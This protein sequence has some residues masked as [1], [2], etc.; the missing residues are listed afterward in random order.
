MI[1]IIQFAL[2]NRF[3]MVVIGILVLGAGYLSYTKLPIDAFPDVSPTL[4]QVFTVS[5]GYSPE[6]IEKYVTFPIEAAMSG[7]P[8]LQLVRSISNFGLS[9]VNLYFDD[10]TDVYFSRQVVGER[11]K[12]AAEQIPEGFGT[13]QM[14]PITSGMGL[15][16]Y[17]YLEDTTG[18]YSLTEL[19]SIQDWLIR[20]PLQTVPGVTEVLGI[21]GWV[22]QY[23]TVL[24]PEALIRYNL[25]VNEI[26]DRIRANNLN[27]GAQF[28]VKNSE[29]FTVRSVGLTTEI[30]DIKNIVVKSVDGIPIYLKQL[31][32]IKVGGAARYGASTRN[33]LGEVVVGQII[34]LFGANSSQVIKDIEQKLVQINGM[35]PDGVTIKPY[36]EQKTLVEAAV[37]TVT[38]ALEEAIIL[39]ILILIVF[40]GAFRPSL[41]VAIAIPFSSLF[42]IIGMDFLGISAN[43]MSFGGIAIAIG[44]MV[45]GSVVI[46]E[47]VDRMLRS[48][49]PGESRIHIILRASVEVLRPIIFAVLI[50]IVV[51]VPLFT[52]EGV[53][54]KT[55][56]PLAYTIS[57]A[58][59][60]SLIFAVFLAPVLSYYLM[61]RPK[62]SKNQ[63][64]EEHQIWI[65]RMMLKIYHPLVTF[66]VKKRSAAVI[67]ATVILIIG[68]MIYP[69]LGSEFTPR[70]MEET[71]V[72]RLTLA[73]S[74]SLDEG[75]R[76]TD[77]VEKRLMKIPDIKEVVSRIGRGEVGSD[78][79]PINVVES[80][81]Q[82][83]PRE[84]W[85]SAKTQLGLED[86]IREKLSDVPGIA[87]NI[88]QPIQ[89]RVDELLSGVRAQIAIKL[90][91]DDLDVLKEKSD[92][93]LSIIEKIPGA[94]DV[95]VNQIGGAPQLLIK[96]DRHKI[97]RYGINIK[98]VQDVIQT[99]IGGSTAGQFFEGVK[100]FDIFVRFAAEFRSTPEQI[101]N[102]LVEAPNGVL[103]PLSQ[104]ASVE[105]IVG[106]RQI[107]REYSQRFIT[108][109]SNVV[110][111]DVGTFVKKGIEAIKSKVN[112]PPGYYVEWG[113][114]FK[115]Q[116]AANSRLAVVMP[117][118]LFIIFILLFSNFNSFKNALL[119][120]LNIP[121]ALVGGI[122]ALWIAGLNLSV[123]ASVGFIALFGIALLN[124]IVLLT[125]FNQ[126][127]K[128]GY[129]I[130]EASIQGA[131]LRLRPVLMTAFAAALGM[132]PL[133]FSTGIGSEVQRPLATVVVGGLFTSTILT[134]LVLP[135]L[136]KWFAIKIRNEEM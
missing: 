105:E 129:S 67:L 24:N 112:L 49:D 104:L 68:G 27:V 136:Y 103:V 79:E 86:V 85:T 78:A 39:V 14:G 13:P 56:R 119:I 98:D 66:F 25:S 124:G 26:L 42:A 90:F 11:L 126:L 82:L 59:A 110:G 35:L 9:I 131:S 1:K 92:K 18:S 99:A 55:F 74:I 30:D 89:L 80:I 115:L 43:L 2:R 81:V 116:Q 97:A 73:P 64:G 47:N 31:A 109:Q 71:I 63:E 107:T 53:A 72:V 52:L 76:L 132:I 94:T 108:I 17:Y 65:V 21:G 29:Q 48:S 61:R 117:I 123:P 113:G 8:K 91:G 101:K 75:T 77:I 122:V 135:A 130:D 133:L 114:Q 84:E 41:V 34:K 118:T 88:T 36:Y 23:Q 28:I 62:K 70:L 38:K 87:L 93:I 83:V 6:E 111:T 125:Y 15:I 16:M 12:E 57:L 120:F 32:D 58:M 40:L 100:R 45:D 51:F 4:V 33:G 69:R 22:K 54:G 37:N 60:G 46:V 3:L 19:R 20:Y 7:L 95:Q 96:V 128:E 121:M 134:L 5:E 50:I 10:G 106:P 127:I 44:M 102:V